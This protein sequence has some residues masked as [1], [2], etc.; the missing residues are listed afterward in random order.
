MRSLRRQTGMSMIG[1]LLVLVVAGFFMLCAF[2]MIPAYGENRY[3]QSALRSLPAGD[4]LEEMSNGAIRKKMLSFYMVNNVR[5]EGAKQIAIDRS[6][7]KLTVNVDYEVRVPLFY[8]IEV[9]MSFANQVDSSRP[10]E[11]C[12]AASE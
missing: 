5:S 1:W 10:N 11:C 2:R 9:V 7:N 3:I 4:D 12:K 6:S 8:N